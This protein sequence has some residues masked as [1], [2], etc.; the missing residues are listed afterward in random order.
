LKNYFLYWMGV[1]SFKL[2]LVHCMG[3]VRSHDH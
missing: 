1:V 3:V 2:H